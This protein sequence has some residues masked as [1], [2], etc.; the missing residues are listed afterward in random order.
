MRRRLVIIQVVTGVLVA[1]GAVSTVLI[2]LA[3]NDIYSKLD[4]NTVRLCVVEVTQWKALEAL[5]RREQLPVII[6]RP[7][8]AL[9]HP[10]NAKP[11]G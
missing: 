10:C 3:I 11:G 2:G 8:P 6:P 1:I 9:P 7:L 5:A 4:N